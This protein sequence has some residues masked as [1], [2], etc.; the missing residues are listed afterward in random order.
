[1][2]ITSSAV[3]HRLAF[4]VRLSVLPEATHPTLPSHQH[5]RFRREQEVG[6]RQRLRAEEVE[7]MSQVP[8]H[9][10]GGGGGGGHADLCQPS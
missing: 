9:S 2:K 7:S 8:R 6:G 10:L 5:F 3:V 4:Q 1:M